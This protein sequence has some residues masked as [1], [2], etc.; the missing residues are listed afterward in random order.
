MSHIWDTSDRFRSNY[1]EGPLTARI[2]CWGNGFVKMR[3]WRNSEQHG[4]TFTLSEDFFLS[5]RCG[6]VTIQ[7]AE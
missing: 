7:S 6:W 2:L 4:T 5:P 1:G 3:R